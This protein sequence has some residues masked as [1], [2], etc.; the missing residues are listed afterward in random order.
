MYQSPVMKAVAM[1][2]WTQ[3]L[4]HWWR[5]RKTDLNPNVAA[6]LEKRSLGAVFQ[7][8]V[9]LR[10]GAVYGHEALMR[11][12]RSLGEMTFDS[13]MDAAKEQ[14]CQRQ[15][16][17][18]CMDQA[19]ELWLADRP[20]GKLFCNISA[21]TLVQLHE[22]DAVDTL[23]QILRKHKMQPSR[24]GLDITGYTRIPHFESLL[25]AI[26]PLRAAGMAIALDDFKA[27]DS[28]MRAWTIVLPDL[29]KMAARWTRNIDT[30]EDNRK[31]VTSLVRLTHKHDCLLLV[32]SVES[33][34]ELRAMRE[35]GVNLAQGYFLGSPAPDLVSSLNL[36]ARAILNPA[37]T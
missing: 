29:V 37:T 14:H 32:K 17:M 33:E 10:N 34:A 35:L 6:I 36:R 24:M 23:L 1:R 30:D 25:E 20:K 9:D 3:N 18:G 28:S 2:Q 31:A 16:E 15:L 12:P 21:Q 8:M 13:L 11:V 27:S 22:S 5:G 7:P 4:Q 19:I 26:K